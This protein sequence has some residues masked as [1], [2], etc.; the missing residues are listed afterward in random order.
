MAIASAQGGSPDSKKGRKKRIGTNKLSP[1]TLT[2]AFNVGNINSSGR[3]G[4]PGA[5]GC[6]RKKFRKRDLVEVIRKIGP[7]NASFSRV[8]LDEGN[9]GSGSKEKA[10]KLS[11][12]RLGAQKESMLHVM[13]TGVLTTSQRYN[14]L[15][16]KADRKTFEL[17]K[18]LDVLATFRLDD[19]A[20]GR[21][22]LCQDPESNRI[23]TMIRKAENT[24]S[25]IHGK[26]NYRQVLRHMLQR[27]ERNKV[28]AQR[29]GALVSLVPD[30]SSKHSQQRG[31]L[32][33][34]HENESSAPSFFVH[35]H[36]WNVVK[37]G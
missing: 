25:E 26:L 11:R 18:L 13:E 23:V 20:L 3:A 19:D 17:R 31:F 2:Q 34:G 22:K 12:G 15:R 7:S 36:L 6:P 28:V 24:R 16:L 8:E 10:A 27:L 33:K 35:I 37:F 29:N 30:G 1:L 9:A 21:M 14:E 5:I 32:R 4:I